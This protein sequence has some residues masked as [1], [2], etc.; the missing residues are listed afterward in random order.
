MA[1]VVSAL[2]RDT[3]E[4][5]RRL[6]EPLWMGALRRR[7]TVRLEPPSPEIAAAATSGK[8]AA[9]VV[10]PSDGWAEPPTGYCLQS[11][12]LRQV[13]QWRERADDQVV[14][15][16]DHYERTHSRGEEVSLGCGHVFHR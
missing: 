4:A 2:M 5:N 14:D 16:H 7:R 1:I 11:E 9:A 8:V 12:E 3:I 13:G 15:E 10:E 6:R